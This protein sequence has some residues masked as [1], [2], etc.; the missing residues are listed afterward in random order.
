M[1]TL[2][3]PDYQVMFIRK[4]IKTCIKAQQSVIV[5]LQDVEDFDNERLALDA[6]DYLNLILKNLPEIEDEEKKKYLDSLNI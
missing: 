2:Q 5:I 6:I 4:I 1:Q 3:L